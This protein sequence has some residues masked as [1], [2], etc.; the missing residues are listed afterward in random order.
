MANTSFLFTPSED[1]R[2]DGGLVVNIPNDGSC[3]FDFYR[4]SEYTRTAPDGSLELSAKEFR[5]EMLRNTNFI[6]LGPEKL[7]EGIFSLGTEQLVRNYDF[8][9][10]AD[11]WI[12]LGEAVIAGLK[13]RLISTAGDPS[14]I[15]A[16]GVFTIDHSYGITYEIASGTGNAT[17]EGISIDTTPGVHTFSLVADSRKL[18]I[19]SDGICDIVFKYIKVNEYGPGFV[20]GPNCDITNEDFRCATGSTEGSSTKF[21]KVFEVG[22]IYK[23]KAFANIIKGSID[24]GSGD[25]LTLQEG[26]SGTIEFYLMAGDT[27]LFLNVAADS[28][29]I[30]DDI[31]IM[32]TAEYWNIS[33]VS[34]LTPQGIHFN[35][36]GQ[37]VS[38]KMDLESK[39]LYKIDIQGT[40]TIEYKANNFEGYAE[41][42]LPHKGFVSSITHNTLILRG[43]STEDAYISSVNL[44][45]IS[46]NVP[47]IDYTDGLP[48][49][50]VEKQST[51]RLIKSTRWKTWVNIGYTINANYAEAPN[52]DMTAGLIT[53]DSADIA[54]PAGSK[55]FQGVLTKTVGERHTI[56]VYVK[57][58]TSTPVEVAIFL[59]SY[60][61]DTYH[62]RKQF[63]VTDEWQ[64]IDLTGQSIEENSLIGTSLVFKTEAPVLTW[65]A[66]LESG[67]I[68]SFINTNNHTVTRLK[69]RITSRDVGSV[70]GPDNTLILTLSSF[71]T[72][73]SKCIYLYSS[74]GHNSISVTLVGH[75]ITISRITN[76]QEVFLETYTVPSILDTH[77]IGIAWN[78]DGDFKTA[79]DGVSQ[80]LTSVPGLDDS[81]NRFDLQTPKG[82]DGFEGKLHE[83][84]ILDE[85]LDDV[86]FIQATT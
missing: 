86:E 78:S 23:I 7:R 68:S 29:C 28:E 80:D 58:P 67:R 69:D 37:E 49:L 33:D 19:E 4:E 60:A 40:G 13:G 76:A 64:R 42:E 31:S 9:F 84:K 65:G 36:I 14:V 12:L 50:L 46:H 62:K 55:I 45:K 1:S 83:I 72:S 20:Y 54:T 44:K 27:E 21:R 18:D 32:Q 51:N 81:Y 3:D 16:K 71:N 11:E 22:E 38:Q 35:D 43:I 82:L 6:S 75:D 47:N 53:P 77:K 79:I 24:I 52:G 17:I 66:Q 59:G 56:S 25:F 30:L 39:R 8:S 10:G 34:R 57:A 41:V 2:K 74:I 73:H 61:G 85:Y 26:Y 5:D 63:T 15:R 48:V 70:I